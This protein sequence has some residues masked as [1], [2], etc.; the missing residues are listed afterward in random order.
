MSSNSSS[1]T[2]EDL[3]Q[4]I[5]VYLGSCIASGVFLVVI[6]LVTA[7]GN[8][9]LLFAIWKDPFKTFR[10]P[11]IFFV[12]GLAVA[13]FLTGITV[14]PLTA[15][16]DIGLY[17]SVKRRDSSII[18]SVQKAGHVAHIISAATMNSSYI[19]LLLFTL[20]QFIAIN[21]PFKQKVLVTKSRVIVS[22]ILA[23]VYAVMFAILSASGV[24][25]TAFLKM[26]LYFHTTGSLLL[27]TIG[28]FC[29]YRAFKSQMKQLQFLK[30]NETLGKQQSIQSRRNRR[31]RQFTIVN[32]LLLTFVL[33]CTLPVTVFFYLQYH[34]KDLTRLE[35]LRLH[36]AGLFSIDVLFL[37]FALDPL[38]YAWRLAQ[39][40]RAL[41]SFL[42]CRRQR[43]HIDG[44][45]SLSLDNRTLASPRMR[46]RFSRGGVEL[47][48]V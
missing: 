12:I 27:L 34:W 24:A 30:A 18:P 42:V 22:V 39:Y 2:Q 26:D 28:Y 21:F 5:Q 41:K 47:A 4:I 45:I 33:S 15:F 19:I 48:R 16:Q 29:L 9:L 10:T 11:N 7:L 37:K 35:L 13:D 20:S 6:T 36:L 8:G 17:I 43:I 25:E 23:W 38:I 40:R 44:V 46:V 1:K 31:E 14:C 32:L 3:K